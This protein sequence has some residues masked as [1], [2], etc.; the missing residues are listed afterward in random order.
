MSKLEIRDAI[1][2]PEELISWFLNHLETLDEAGLQKVWERLDM[3]NY[4]PREMEPSV[5]KNRLEQ[6]TLQMETDLDPEGPYMQSL[7]KKI[8][9]EFDWITTPLWKKVLVRMGVMR[10]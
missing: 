8:G 6:Q 9:G 1:L 4:D 2:P 5:L 10:I 7:F 3:D